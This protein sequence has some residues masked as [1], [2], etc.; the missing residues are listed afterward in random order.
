VL[1]L[2]SISKANP[3]P[4]RRLL[5]NRIKA[6]RSV[7]HQVLARQINRSALG[8]PFSLRASAHPVTTVFIRSPEQQCRPGVKNGVIPAKVTVDN[9]AAFVATLG[10]CSENQKAILAY[11]R[12]AQYNWPQKAFP[13]INGRTLCG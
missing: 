10:A 1:L 11:P 7:T 4:R 6:I 12:S 13:I 5:W 3:N 2:S 9:R 8:A